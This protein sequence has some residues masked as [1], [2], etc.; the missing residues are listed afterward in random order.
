MSITTLSLQA[1]IDKD[2]VEARTRYN[3]GLD[4]K[5]KTVKEA[6]NVVH[7]KWMNKMGK[8]LGVVNPSLGQEWFEKVV[9]MEPQGAGFSF[10]LEKLHTL[11][12]STVKNEVRNRWL[13]ISLGSMRAQFGV[14]VSDK[15][16][17]LWVAKETWL[18]YLVEQCK[19]TLQECLGIGTQIINTFGF[20]SYDVGV[21]C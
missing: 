16:Y 19:T 9:T 12:C 5:H 1:D 8:L 6:E 14:P 2:L 7:Y 21:S 10:G 4:K 20:I 3:S 13:T 18:E 15:D 17:R 11:R